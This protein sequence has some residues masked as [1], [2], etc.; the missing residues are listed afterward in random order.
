[1]S[2]IRLAADTGSDYTFEQAREAGVVVVPLVVTFGDETYLDRVL[3]QDS[4]WEKAQQ[5]QP[6]TSQPPVGA[7]E[8]AFAPL[9]EAG[10]EV[11]CIAITSKLSGTY[12]SARTAAQR[13]GDRVTVFDSLSLSWGQR[14]QIEAAQQAAAAGKSMDQVLE[15]VKDVQ[16][17]TRIFFVLDTLEYLERGGRAAKLIAVVKKVVSLFNIKPVL[18]FKEGELALSGTANSFKRGLLRLQREA[19]QAGPCEQLAVLHTR[20]AEAAADF[21]A[22]LAPRLGLQPADVTVTEIGAAV[23][24]H[25]GPGVIGIAL[26]LKPTA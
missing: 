2:P 6:K 26:L 20:N 19:A 22:D 3:D 1:M 7:F 24:A 13:F 11:L 5:A 21:A 8:E 25:G 9:V 4:F 15:V 16:E 17:R 18:T 23:S 10:D 14:Y 12:G